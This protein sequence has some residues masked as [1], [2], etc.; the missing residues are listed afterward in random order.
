MV[1]YVYI[2]KLMTLSTI[3]I[4]WYRIDY[5]DNNWNEFTE[6]EYWT[7]ISKLKESQLDPITSG[8]NYNQTDI[9]NHIRKLK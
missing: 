2:D 4:D 9:L 7:I 8:Q 5:I 3:E 1:D 6:L